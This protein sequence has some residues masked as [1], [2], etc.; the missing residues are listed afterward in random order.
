MTIRTTTAGELTAFIA[1][2]E[3]EREF[4]PPA[5]GDEREMHEVVDQLRALILRLQN[6]NAELRARVDH[7][8]ALRGSL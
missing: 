8:R 4:L 7:L 1:L 6:D 2:E 5:D 3:L